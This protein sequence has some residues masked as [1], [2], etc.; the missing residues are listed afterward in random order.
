MKTHCC[1]LRVSL[2]GRYV[3]GLKTEFLRSS[4]VFHHN[5]FGDLKLLKEYTVIIGPVLK[6]WFFDFHNSLVSE[7][8]SNV[9]EKSGV[10]FL[11]H[12][13]FYGL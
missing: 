13:V 5:E 8:E 10:F 11:F 2:T 1:Q 12:F 3:T 6:R 4:I 7:W 9:E